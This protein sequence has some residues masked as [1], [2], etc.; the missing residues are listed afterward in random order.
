M[1]ATK[2][3]LWALY[4]ITKKDWRGENL[5]FE[6]ASEM[7]SELTRESREKENKVLSAIINGR[8]KG[9]EAMK[10]FREPD[11]IIYETEGL[12]ER[13]KEGRKA[14]YEKSFSGCGWCYLLT[15]D[16][17]LVRILK[18]IAKKDK[19]E[20]EWRHKEFTLQKNYQSGW[21]IKCAECYSN[22]HIERLKAYYKGIKEEL[23]KLGYEVFVHVRLD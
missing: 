13:P 3:Q 21:K 16:R 11:A 15:W 18:R 8:K 19:E 23:E 5:T 9:I 4:C 7:L 2:R 6:K 14:Y 1:Q 20:E 10:E 17:E 22:G 12:S